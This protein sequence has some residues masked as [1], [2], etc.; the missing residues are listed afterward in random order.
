MAKIHVTTS[1]NGEPMEY[2]C[3]PGDTICDGTPAGVPNFA[4]TAYV[5]NGMPG[6]AAD[7]TVGRL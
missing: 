6:Q 5:L 1:I 7:F 2:L 3:E 4:H